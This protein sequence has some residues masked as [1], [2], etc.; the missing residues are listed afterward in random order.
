MHLP[1]GNVFL[2]YSFP[3]QESYFTKANK[4]SQNCKSNKTQIQQRFSSFP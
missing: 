3:I 2:L 1:N 4:D